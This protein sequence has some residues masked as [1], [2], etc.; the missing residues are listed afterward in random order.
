MPKSKDHR[1]GR[2]TRPR[3]CAPLPSHAG[4][5]ADSGAGRYAWR[6]R[7]GLLTIGD[8]VRL[9]L[10]CRYPR[11]PYWPPLPEDRISGGQQ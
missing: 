11:G 6:R 4:P 7:R 10:A 8:L 2:T 1:G 9:Y 5:S 3:L